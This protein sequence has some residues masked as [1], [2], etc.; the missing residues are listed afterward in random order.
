MQVHQ[1]DQPR[2]PP[3]CIASLACVCMMAACP[4]HKQKTNKRRSF[5]S[6]QMSH[7]HTTLG[8][9]RRQYT[10]VHYTTLLYN[11]NYNCNYNYTT[12]I[13]LLQLQYATTTT[14]LHHAISSS[15]VWGDRCNHCSLSK[16]HNSNHLSVHQWICSAIRDS[17]QPTSPIGFLFLKLP[18]LPC[19]AL[20][21]LKL[22]VAD[23]EFRM[24]DDTTGI[25]I[26]P[27]HFRTN[28]I[29]WSL[30]SH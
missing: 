25:W 2:L 4:L 10:T 15:C 24:H 26:F 16:K 28:S 21:V 7:T 17:Q 29:C 5:T 19:A 14:A 6:L 3:S 27:H 12:L 13:K 1:G 22:H 11:Y 20:L 9:T 30:K 23:G 8:Y 18:P